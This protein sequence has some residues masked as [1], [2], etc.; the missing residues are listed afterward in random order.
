MLAQPVVR[1]P[2]LTVLVAVALVAACDQANPSEQ[3][4]TPNRGVPDAAA[5]KRADVS[6]PP[7]V[8]FQRDAT[9]LRPA[10]GTVTDID[11]GLCVQLL[12]GGWGASA[13]GVCPP[14]AI[15]DA[16][17]DGKISKCAYFYGCKIACS[18]VGALWSCKAGI[19]VG[20]P[21]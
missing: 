13:C 19:T 20:C 21:E 5:V 1:A 3:P 12:D 6:D 8:T 11:A 2:S 15:P 7:P 17:C 9:R 10:P 18:C 4:A 16:G 14:D